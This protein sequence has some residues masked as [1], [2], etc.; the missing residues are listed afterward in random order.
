MRRLIIFVFIALVGGSAAFSQITFQQRYGIG[1]TFEFFASALQTPDEG[2]LLTG[3]GLG[4]G[5]FEIDVIKVDTG[6]VL[7]WAKNYHSGS[8]LFPYSDQYGVSKIIPTTDGNYVISG[9]REGDFFLMKID[10]S[11]N[12]IWVK[13]YNK[14]DGDTLLSVKQTSDGGFIAVGRTRLSSNDS[15][16]AY[17]LKTDAYGNY[18]WGAV[19]DNSSVNSDDVLYDVAEDPGNGYI[20]VGYVS[21]VFNSGNDTTTDI[22]V[23]KTDLSGNLLWVKTIGEDGDNDQARYIYRDG[24]NF[25]VTGSTEKSAVGTDVVFIQMDNS[26]NIAAA[27]SYNYGLAD[28]GNKIVKKSNGDFA[29]L[30]TDIASY[31]IFKLDVSSSGTFLSGYD[32]TGSFSFALTVDGQ[33]TQDG[34]F[35]LATMGNDYSFYL[36]KT[37]PSGSSGCYENS[38]SLGTT[39]LG[40]TVANLTGSYTTGGSGG[41]PSVTADDFDI[42]TTVV[43]CA[44]IPC[45]TPVVSISPVDPQICA[46]ESQTLTASGSNNSGS[47][48][49]YSWNTGE[50]TASITV[51]PATQTTYTVT[52]YVGSCPSNPVSVTVYVNPTPS[53]SIS[54]D[55]SVCENST[56]VVYSTQNNSGNTYSWSV[57]GG[58]IVSGQNTSSIT[59]NWGSAGSGSVSVTET[60][61]NTGC[62]GTDVLN[63]TINSLPT[64]TASDNS[65]VCEGSTLTLTGGANGMTSYAWTGPNGFT[66]N[67]QSPTVS[68]SATAAMSGTYTLTVTDANGCTNTATTTVTVNALPAV[69]ASS[70]SPTCEGFPL[71]L[72]GG[73]NGMTSYAWSGP[74]GFTSNEQS[75]TVSD[76][77]TTAMS[78]TYSI[79]V[80]DANGCT[81]TASADVTIY[82]T[83]VASATSNSPVC[84]GTP[85]NLIGLPDGMASYSW[86]GT[87]GFSSSSQNP[88]VSNTASQSMAGIYTL[89]VTDEHGCYNSDTVSVTV[90]PQPDIEFVS[91]HNVSCF[92][93][94]DGSA[95]V[96]A[97]GASSPYNYL[98]ITGD[99][100]TVADNLASG[101]YRVSVTDAN[102][103]LSVDS[104][105]I[106]EPDSLHIDFAVN[107]VSCYGAGDGEI[108]ANVTGG[109]TPYSYSWNTGSTSNTISGL[110]PGSY[111]VTV[112]DA[113]GCVDE[114]SANITQPEPIIV[115]ETVSDPLCYGDTINVSLETTGG[116]EPYSYSWSTGDTGSVVGVLAGDYV[117][118]VTDANGCD[119]II[120]VSVDYGDLTPVT[121]TDSV[122]QPNGYEFN[123]DI[124]ASGGNPPYNYL[125]N[126]GHTTEDITVS[127]AGN[128]IVTVTDINGCSAYDTVN[129][130]INLL[131][132]TVI[133]PNGDGKND[134]WRI[135]NIGTYDDVTI[136][137]YNRWGNLI[138]EFSGNGYDYTDVKNQWDGTYNGKLV[139]FGEYL[140]IITLNGESYKGTVLV[141]Y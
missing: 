100:T 83:P 10:P 16:D 52:G 93:G 48:D 77:A 19:W 89:T 72:I 137:V 128:Y 67:E 22:L 7:Q 26:G 132:P 32:Y 126:S 86:S 27:H 123:I 81:N 98:W 36:I 114:R 127:T 63:V 60:N 20:A 113:N 105:Q 55:V 106:T 87:N 99:T 33:E 131:I 125:W 111:S 66:S 84:E 58:T 139:P 50:T 57:S 129:I 121:V 13:D 62:S 31:N 103:C 70:N 76:S 109:T 37:D 23:L 74:N 18:Q 35:M 59:V 41:T 110:Q 94:N 88:T 21:E 73:P 45:D 85:L 51:S 43:D 90:L 68:D 17:I 49:S 112:T 91:V 47:C 29:I 130:K 14:A 46:G 108:T 2:Y 30:C 4:L 117:T 5:Y 6:G 141:K 118:T 78:G 92:G 54:G 138:F 101:W 25:Y 15:L 12:I 34:G 44:H 56:N 115:N 107:N 135:L 82:P 24:S 102:G 75:P 3:T 69:S 65:P 64:A 80:T 11:G 136:K 133:T 120:Q 40:F 53:P 79:T 61:P 8:L 38:L 95:E 104:V 124:T 28:I 42:D 97:S 119:T 140:Y 1:N 116:T 134:T 9:M 122:Y 96:S 71:T 39:T